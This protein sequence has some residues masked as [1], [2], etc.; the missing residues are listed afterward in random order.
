DHERDRPPSRAPQAER[1]RH[2][3]RDEREPLSLRDL[4][5]H[6]ARD[7]PRGRGARRGMS[8]EDQPGRRDV[9]PFALGLSRALLAQIAP[10]GCGGARSAADAKA[11]DFAPNAW[12]RITPDDKVHFVL[13]RVEM[14]Q[15]TMTSHAQLVAEELEIDPRHLIVDLAPADRAYD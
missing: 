10:P 1:P 4:R 13:D 15:G 9:L 6:S 8:S 5:A 12:I 14:G 2:R 3:R 11:S 7:P